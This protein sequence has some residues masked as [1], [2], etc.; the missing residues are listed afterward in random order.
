MNSAIVEYL[1]KLDNQ[2]KEIDRLSELAKKN[3]HDT[4]LYNSLC[5][6]ATVLCVSHLGKVRISRSFLPKLTR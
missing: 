4:E 5:R 2:W 6:A 3:Q 1:D